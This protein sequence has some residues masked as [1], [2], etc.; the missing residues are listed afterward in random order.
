MENR[1]I[2][3]SNV[4]LSLDVRYTKMEIYFSLTLVDIRYGI[5]IMLSYVTTVKD[6]V[7]L[8][9]SVESK[10]QMGLGYVDAAMELIMKQQTVNL[11]VW[12]VIIV[13]E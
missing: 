1:I 9:P 3:L 13:L 12:S 7:I 11:K 2:I 4:H 10:L 8:S 5:A 6:M